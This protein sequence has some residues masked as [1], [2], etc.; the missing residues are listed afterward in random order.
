MATDAL[1][2]GPNGDYPYWPRDSQAGTRMPTGVQQHRTPDG[3]VVAVDVTKT[4]S[5]GQPIEPDGWNPAD[6]G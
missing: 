6:Q 5:N 4:D 1:D 3:Q 2:P